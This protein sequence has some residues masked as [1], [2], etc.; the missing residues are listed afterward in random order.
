[1][2]LTR[3]RLGPRPKPGSSLHLHVLGTPPA[4]VLSQDQTLREKRLEV[5]AP[6][7]A[8]IRS[9]GTGSSVNRRVVMSYGRRVHI[10]GGRHDGVFSPPPGARTQSALAPPRGG[11]GSN[12]PAELAPRVR[13]L[14][15]FQRPLRP[16]AAGLAA[17]SHLIGQKKGLSQRGRTAPP[18][19][20]G[21]DSRLLGRSFQG[22]SQVRPPSIASERPREKPRIRLLRGRGGGILAVSQRHASRRGGPACACAGPPGARLRRAPPEPGR[23]APVRP[24]YRR[25]APRPARSGVLPRCG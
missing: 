20:I 3:S 1:V 6:A 25:F 5:S 12:V 8:G 16:R 7:K 2:L 4:F 9:R 14:L 22:P 18:K 19:G 17:G 23:A 24:P 10:L 21:W 13:T 15:S 11:S